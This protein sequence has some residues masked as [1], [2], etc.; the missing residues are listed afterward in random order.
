MKLIALVDIALDKAR[1]LDFV[2]PLA[3]R[4]YLLPIFYEGAHAKLTGFEG[5]V[6]WFGAPPH[7][8]G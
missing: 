3:I 8:A 4:I 6:Q 5:L 2:A 1:A 7:R